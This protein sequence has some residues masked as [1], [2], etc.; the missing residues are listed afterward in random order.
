MST[1]PGVL[2]L[3]PCSL[4]NL[5]VGGLPTSEKTFLNLCAKDS[6]GREEEAGGTWESTRSWLD[7]TVDESDQMEAISGLSCCLTA[8]LG[9]GAAPWVEGGPWCSGIVVAERRLVG[10]DRG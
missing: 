5:A 10:G 3:V 9:E 2:G 6:F 8:L 1:V 4:S 7:Q